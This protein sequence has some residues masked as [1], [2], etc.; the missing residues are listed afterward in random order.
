MVGGM[1]VGLDEQLMRSTPRIEILVRRGAVV[2]G[3]SSD[4]G[5]LLVGLAHDPITLRDV[6]S[7]SD[8]PGG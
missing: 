3:T 8:S 5:D 2:R 6:T 7:E 4:G 1:L